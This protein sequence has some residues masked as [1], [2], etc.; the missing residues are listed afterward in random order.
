MKYPTIEHERAANKV[1][2]IYSKDKRVMAILLV[3]SCARGKATKDSCLD[4]TLIIKNIKDADKIKKN[5]DKLTL[6]VKELL[7]VRKVGKFSHIDL[8]IG[9]GKFKPKPRD[10]ESGPDEFELEIG[11]TYDYSKVL[12]ERENYFKELSRRY[13][14][15]YEEILRKKK[16]A[17]AVKYCTNNL[18]HVPLYVNRGLYFAAFDRLYKASQ[19]FMQALFISKKVYPISY[20]KWIKEQFVDI[21]NMP[22]LYRKFVEIHEIKN[23]ESGEIAE[24]AEMLRKMLQDNVK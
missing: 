22:E 23:F 8:H 2:E 10:W 20:A 1:V 16:L 3:N 14:P 7:D 13:I 9:D 24:K 17:E 4:L 19:E 6:S 5:F 15:Y 18:D 12:F 11:N 21:L